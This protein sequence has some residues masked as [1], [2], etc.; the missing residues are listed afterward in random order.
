MLNILTLWSSTQKLQLCFHGTAWQTLQKPTKNNDKVTSG[1]VW[2]SLKN[3]PYSH[4]KLVFSSDRVS[5]GVVSGI[6][7][8]RE[9]VFPFLLIQSL[10]RSLRSS[11]N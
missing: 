10:I 7:R 1:S 6:L 11:E 5:V 9:S 4:L 3:L 8:S 2:P